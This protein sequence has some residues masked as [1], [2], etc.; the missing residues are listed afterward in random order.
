MLVAVVS[1]AR[2]A[3]PGIHVCSAFLV[4]RTSARAR[5]WLFSARCVLCA[6]LTAASSAAR[7]ALPVVRPNPNIER[8]GVLRGGLLAVT[9]EAKESLSRLNGADRPPMTI[10]SVEARQTFFG[11]QR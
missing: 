5:L 1:E 2:I 6:G 3:M 8:A 9:L 11:L 10:S 7:R 4:R